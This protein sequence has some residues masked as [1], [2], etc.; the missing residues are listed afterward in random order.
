MYKNKKY[1]YLTNYN[2]SV[3]C[4]CFENSIV[5]NNF[6]KLGFRILFLRFHSLIIFFIIC[7]YSLNASIIYKKYMLLKYSQF[8]Y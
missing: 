6:N 5:K 1:I 3:K 7:L 4:F 8:I 2:K